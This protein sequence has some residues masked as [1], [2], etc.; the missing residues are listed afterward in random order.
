M[1]CGTRHAAA[2]RCEVRLGDTWLEVCDD[3]RG[4]GVG[5]PGN[6]LAGLRERLATVGGTVVAGPLADGGFR[7]RA[8]VV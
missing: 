8:E 6:G 2:S 1:C 3:G 5:L 7:L 4:A